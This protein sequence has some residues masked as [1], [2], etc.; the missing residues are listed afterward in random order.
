M[1]TSLPPIPFDTA[2]IHATKHRL[3]SSG[4]SADSTLRNVSAQGVPL[5]SSTQ[6]SSHDRLLDANQA[7]SSQPSAPQI[8]ASIDITRM[9]ISGCRCVRA[10]RGSFSVAKNSAIPAGVFVLEAFT[11]R[12]WS[13]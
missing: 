13:T 12:P 4:S 6:V 7:I 3:N 9:L 11:P 10:T 1:A 8:T 5:G 2:A